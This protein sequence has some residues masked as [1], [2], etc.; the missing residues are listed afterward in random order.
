[1][2]LI[3]GCIADDFTGAT[4]LASTLVKEGVRT[5]VVIGV[6]NCNTDVSDAQAVVIALKSRTAETADAIRWSL[7]SLTWLKNRNCKQY[8]F[9]YC[10]T[11]DSTEKGNIGPVADALVEALDTDICTVCPAFPDNERTVYKGMLFVGDLLLS[12]SSMK[13]HPLTPMKDSNL[14][15]LLGQQSDG[16]SGLVDLK[17][18]RQGAEAIRQQL[19]CLQNR[20]VR[21]A[22]VDAVTNDDLQEIGKSLSDHQLVTGGSAVAAGLPANYHQAG[23][24]DPIHVSELSSYPGRKAVLSGSCSSTSLTQL[25]NVIG[26]WPSYYIDPFRLEGE[27]SIVDD[28][29][30]WVSNQNPTQP[31]VIYSSTNPETLRKVHAKLDGKLAAESIEITFGRIARRLSES[32]F[33]QFIVA[34]GETSGSV[35]RGLKINELK[36]G[37]EIDPGVPWCQTVR[38]KNL[39]ITLKSGNFGVEE[40]FEKAFRLLN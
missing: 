14:A 7:D 5:V 27:H 6:P 32:G 4:D 22:I 2:S 8:F 28:I 29:S 37:K 31:V 17:H 12:E 33:D 24:I 40:F 16:K 36:V 1:M 18:V 9:K 10:S 23:L 3:L 25:T 26:R 15:R 30:T 21:Y 34:G 13:D 11:F 20:G 35:V 39:A 38:G 19:D